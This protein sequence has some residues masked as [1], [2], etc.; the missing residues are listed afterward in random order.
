MPTTVTK[1]IGTVGR[2]YST[3]QA[4]EDA[5]PANLVT[6]D[7]IW[8]GECY[9]DSEFLVAGTALTIA[10]ETTDATRYIELTTATGQSFQDHASVRTNALTYNQARGVGVRN[11]N[12][13]ADLIIVGVSNT[14]ISL[15]QLNRA[16][17]HSVLVGVS[18]NPGGL[19]YKDL[20]CL[21][22]GNDTND[23]GLYTSGGL[24]NKVINCVVIVT[25]VSGNAFNTRASTTYIGCTAIRTTNRATAGTGF[26]MGT[27]TNNGILQSC[28]AFGFTSPASAAGWVAAS[29]KNNATQAASG[30]PGTNN[31]HSVAYSATTPFTQAS[32]VGTDMRAIDA[33]TL[34]NNGFLD[35]TNA[36]RD[37]SGFT[38][39]AT[40]TIGHWELAATALAP[41]PFQPRPRW[42]GRAARRYV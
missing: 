42:V 37:I 22:S 28:N 21:T 6:V 32:N 30:W 36:P 25:S 29:C 3:L 17:G 5:S 11:T 13:Y 33:T 24:S 23:S 8:R 1:S 18:G 35:A 38:R 27:G 14:R 15:L 19:I 41:A 20:L 39:T 12:N 9:N 26:I 10:G 40:P 4:W 16:G 31:Q 2:D 7:Q 34:A